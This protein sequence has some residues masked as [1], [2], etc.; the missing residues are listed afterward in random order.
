MAES[1]PP[2]PATLPRHGSTSSLSTNYR[3]NPLRSLFSRVPSSLPLSPSTSATPSTGHTPPYPPPADPF[4]PT[5]PITKVIIPTPDPNNYKKLP[6]EFAAKRAVVCETL[7]T[8]THAGFSFGHSGPLSLRTFVLLPRALLR[9]SAKPAP[10]ATPEIVVH[11]TSE[12]VAYAS[13]DIPG[14]QYVLKVAE[15]TRRTTTD[16]SPISPTAAA[17]PHSA[18][19]SLHLFHDD[20]PKTALLVFS[21]SA[22]LMRWLGIVRDRIRGDPAA[23]R[24]P[25][26]D[27][28]VFYGALDPVTSPLG[29]DHSTE[30]L[31]RA[32]ST[33]T[34]SSVAGSSKPA[35]PRS[36]FTSAVQASSSTASLS[37]SSSSS[38]TAPINSLPDDKPKRAP[39]ARRESMTMPSS[40]AARLQLSIQ[41]AKID[42]HR[43]RSASDATTAAPAL[44]LTPTS[45]TTSTTAPSTVPPQTVS[46]SFS[47]ESRNEPSPSQSPSSLA[48]AAGPASRNSSVDKGRK[49]KVVMRSPAGPPPSG[50]LPPVPPG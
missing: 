22:D 5:R 9:Y 50:P 15:R 33:T 8:D 6:Y 25:R 45:T 7:E 18:S 34:L 2:E 47:F 13:D 20:R 43:S 24:K 3:R 12:A 38:S 27:S 40:S 4:A 19:I 46:P 30:S 21:S 31:V 35:D 16:D 41:R 11:L 29:G 14:R 48:P 37:S 17:P 10:N 32:M 39:P 28:T 42:A 36:F 49:K 1:P 23:A 44:T 26:T